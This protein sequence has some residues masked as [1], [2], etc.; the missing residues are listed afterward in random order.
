MSTRPI[1]PEEDLHAFIDGEL[2]PSRQHAIERI[3]SEDPA[4]AER[5]AKFR[6]D[7]ERL[8]SIYAPLLNRPVPR[9]WEALIRQNRMSSTRRRELA[10][11]TAIAASLVLVVGGIWFAKSG[12]STTQTPSL[13]SEAL[14]ARSG[15]LRPD[16]TVSSGVNVLSAGREIS[17][18]L[19]MKAKAPLLTRFGY[20]LAALKSYEADPKRRT[21]ELIYV[22][23]AGHELTL[24]VSRS[25]GAPRFDQYES[26][27]L[28]ICIWQDDIVGMVMAGNL[29]AAE[30]QRLA[31]LAYDGLT[32]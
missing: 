2:D 5:V 21:I 6:E 7:K 4:L 28:R 22:N 27:G 24:Y 32:T 29:S 30:M 17:A 18:V 25:V 14:A 20:R 16:A 12:V 1:I 23:A 10:A 9:S 15:D 19:A 31:T 26:S 8:A 13:A 11:I 3:V